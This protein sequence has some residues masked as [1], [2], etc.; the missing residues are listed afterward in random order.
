MKLK[1]EWTER[2]K[3]SLEYYC[4][5]IEVASPSS[6]KRVKKEIILTSKS[7]S[8]NPYLYQVDE[9]YPDNSGTIRRFFRWN[10]RVVYQVLEE[11]VIV[12]EVYHT[13]SSPSTS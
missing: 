10:Y 4:S 9:Y 1:V 13:R 7:L 5:I 2:A 3:S 6:A 12:L 11:K 8:Q